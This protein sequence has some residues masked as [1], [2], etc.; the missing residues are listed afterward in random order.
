MKRIAPRL[1]TPRSS[2][3][4]SSDARLLPDLLHDQLRRLEVF[5]LVGAGLWGVGLLM[6]AVVFPWTMGAEAPL[7]HGHWMRP[8]FS[9]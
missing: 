8:F 5:A 9:A 1:D 6:D 7:R 4:P 2:V 3:P